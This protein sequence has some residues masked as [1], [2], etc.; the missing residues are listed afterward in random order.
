[1]RK[2]LTA[3]LLS[4]SLALGLAPQIP[5]SAAENIEFYYEQDGVTRKGL[6]S[7]EI[8]PYTYYNVGDEDGGTVVDVT[9][10]RNLVEDE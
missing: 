4:L 2:R 1:M 3:I 7:I 8:D 10:L 6:K 9:F 5:A